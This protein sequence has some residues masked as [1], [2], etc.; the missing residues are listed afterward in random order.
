MSKYYTKF[1]L[2]Y[3]STIFRFIEEIYSTYI[4]NIKEQNIYK[5]ILNEIEKIKQRK[6]SLTPTD[7]NIIAK[8]ISSFDDISRDVNR[9]FHNDRYKSG[10]LRD[11]L[12]RVLEAIS[13]MKKEIGYCQGMNFIAGAL[14]CLCNCEE[15][16]FWI[17]L[18]LLNKYE[19][20]NLFIKVGRYNANTQSNPY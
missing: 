18:I 8:L 15:K 4:G 5:N 10:S 13:Y 6:R 7:P 12:T 2:S 9:T 3:N 1:I 14:I 20:N 19:L 16:G 11:E 17:L